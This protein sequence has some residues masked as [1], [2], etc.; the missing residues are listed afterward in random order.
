MMRK[1]V[2][3]LMYGI[4]SYRQIKYICSLER[5][6]WRGTCNVPKYYFN[7][8][9]VD[10]TQG[11]SFGWKCISWKGYIDNS[12]NSNLI[13]I[14]RYGFVFISKRE[15]CK[16]PFGSHTTTISP[17]IITISVNYTSHKSLSVTY[18]FHKSLSDYL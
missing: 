18:P 6:L 12:Q 11:Y 17:K 2:R 1:K 10:N 16:L 7:V 8:N 15:C 3:R 13:G 14:T 9:S 4:K 5:R